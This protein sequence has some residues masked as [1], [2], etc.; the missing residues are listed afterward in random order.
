V[1]P[2]SASTGKAESYGTAAEAD[3]SG[4]EATTGAA[5]WML[6][7]DIEAGGAPEL[8]GNILTGGIPAGTGNLAPAEGG[9]GT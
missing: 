1:N 2:S 8:T 5:D 7:N 9:G 6:G 4:A 3:P